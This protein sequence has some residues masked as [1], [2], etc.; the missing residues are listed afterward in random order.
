M[1]P[2]IERLR[3]EILALPAEERYDLIDS[4]LENREVVALGLHPAWGPEIERRFQDFQNGTTQGVPWE[5][6]EKEL[7]ELVGRQ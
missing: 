1:S 5:D 3:E 4:V 2:T 6:V 7:D